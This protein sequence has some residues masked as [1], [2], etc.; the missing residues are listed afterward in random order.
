MLHL[1]LTSRFTQLLGFCILINIAQTI[2]FHTFLLP[3]PYVEVFN[4]F[5][6]SIVKKGEQICPS[7]TKLFDHESLLV[8]IEKAKDFHQRGGNLISIEKYLNRETQNTLDKLDI[9]FEFDIKAYNEA[10]STSN[11]VDDLALYY[12]THDVPKGGYSQNLPGKMIG[13]NANRK[14]G[15]L[16]QNRWVNII[17]PAT[18]ERFKVA[19]GEVGP[20]CLQKIRFAGGSYQGKLFCIPPDGNVSIN[21]SKSEKTNLQVTTTAADSPEECN[22][23]SIGSNDQWSFETE[24]NKKLSHC[25]THTFDCTLENNQPQ[26]KP[27]SANIHFYP[28]CIGEDST[29]RN[30]KET[31][32][33]YLPYHKMLKL[34]KI[35]QAPKL[36]K[37]DIEGFEFGV[38]P[39]LLRNTPTEIL[40]EQIQVEVHWGTRMIDNPSMLRT[41]QA[42]EIS[43]LFGQLFNYGGY[44]PVDVR[45]FDPGCV[46]CLEV[47]LVRAICDSS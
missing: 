27:K 12:K 41:R 17:E 8:M 18:T 24:V 3:L 39:S 46:A 14:D 30:N 25:A 23:F 22:I 4:V 9:K 38:I 45:F 44:L 28:Y 13:S 42:A 5:E 1:K 16:F 47:L 32:G 19:I 37:M 20:D 34:T 29:S 26:R 10:K 15:P 35:T 33:Q 7:A 21:K 40:P 11:V 2:F 43:L 36:L 31:K 6:D